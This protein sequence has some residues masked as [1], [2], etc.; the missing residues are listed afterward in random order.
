MQDSSSPDGQQTRCGADA[1]SR[2]LL[3][4]FYATLT[5]HPY[6]TQQDGVDG[7]TI[8]CH[9]ILGPTSESS[10]RKTD[11][12]PEPLGRVRQITFARRVLDYS[13]A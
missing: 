3:R 8:E 4:G 13:R 9:V 10:S 1:P 11:C 7:A 5:P 2:D 12:N 6:T